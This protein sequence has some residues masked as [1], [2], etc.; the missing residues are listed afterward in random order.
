[1]TLDT[2]V[3]CVLFDLDGTL[4]DTAP[5]FYQAVNTLTAEHNL[6]SVSMELISQT[7]SDGARALIQLAFGIV[8]SS[9]GFAALNNRL[10][11]L[12]NEKLLDTESA[13]YPGIDQLLLELDKAGIPW[14]IVTNK[15]E[16][17][18]LR[19]L[20]ELDLLSRCGVLV[21]PDHVQ[22]RKPHPQPILLALEK[23]KQNTECALY[24]G[25]HIRDVQAARNAGVMAVAASYGYLK[26]DACVEEWGANFI[27]NSADQTLGLLNRLKKS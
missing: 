27:L 13:L 25:D 22:Q 2:S 18:C 11:D 14:G 8:E 20:R 9:P 3:S 16:K 5:D 17:Y 1:M 24:I 26:K 12:Y 19:L 21:C 6:P 7:V 10:L 4:I 23:L 15:P